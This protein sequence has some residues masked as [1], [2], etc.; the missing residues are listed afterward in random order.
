MDPYPWGERV[1]GWA[2]YASVFVSYDSD[3]SSRTP[4]D[5]GEMF[6]EGTL[7]FVAGLGGIES[8]AMMTHNVIQ[9]AG[10]KGDVVEFS[11]NTDLW[12][13]GQYV[14]YRSST[15]P[16]NYF[17]G[18]YSGFRVQYK[19]ISDAPFRYFS[20]VPLSASNSMNVVTNIGDLAQD[21][22]YTEW[23]E[24]GVYYTQWHESSA[25]YRDGMALESAAVTNEAYFLLTTTGNRK[26]PSVTSTAKTG[27]SFTLQ[28]SDEFNRSVNIQRSQSLDSTNWQTIGQGITNKA[29]TDTN[30]PTGS[31]FYRL[32]V[33]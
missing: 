1:R 18:A 23:H 24:P 29:F 11:V 21:V 33:P 19:I 12:F 4:P 25:S 27:S 16:T 22:F 15:G 5:Y 10:G 9:G 8:W 32:A 6:L 2:G 26:L 20:N 28:W 7:G 30:P 14:P 17:Q 31:A 3:F 13:E